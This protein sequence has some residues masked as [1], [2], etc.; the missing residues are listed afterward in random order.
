MSCLEFR[1]VSFTFSETADTGFFHDLRLSLDSNEVTL[2]SGPSGCG[3]STILNLAAGIYPQ[4]GGKLVAGEIV[5]DDQDITTLDANQRVALVAMMFQNPDL[6]FCMDTVEHEILFCLENLGVD[7]AMMAERVISALR[8]CGIEALKERLLLTLSGGEKQKA[9]LACLV[10]LR[11]QW[12]LLDEPFANVDEAAAHEIIDKLMVLHHQGVGLFVVD[13]RTDLWLDVADALYWLDGQQQMIRIPDNLDRHDAMQLAAWHLYKMG[14]PYR[15]P[16][17][18]PVERDGP[19]VLSLENIEVTHGSTVLLAQ[20]NYSFM[21]GKIY[22]IVG[23]SGS[24]KSTLFNAISGIQRYKGKITLHQKVLRRTRRWK[25][26]Q[27]GFVTQNSQDQFVAETVIQEIELGLGR[28]S[29]IECAQKLLRGIDLWGYRYFSPYM[30]SQGQQ[31]RL[32]VAALLAYD[33]RLLICDEP[34]YAQDRD[35]TI[36]IMDELSKKARDHGITIIF[37]THD[38]QLARD[39]ADVVLRLERGVLHEET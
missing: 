8:F 19:A 28:H 30:L 23:A 17:K 9:M 27:V 4:N 12:I 35:H 32:G 33:C 1:G 20:L 3:K 24:G 6:Q 13:H 15:S 2:L 37:S 7:P 31:R 22:A 36:N 38:R 10:A 26:G 21:A 34:T 25:P 39:Y 14:T 5:I 16:Q 18:W 11:P 29:S